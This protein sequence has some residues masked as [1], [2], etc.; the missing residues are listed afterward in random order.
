[1]ERSGKSR[2]IQGTFEDHKTSLEILS[3]E[4]STICSYQTPKVLP[5][6]LTGKLLQ[7]APVPGVPNFGIG[8]CSHLCHQEAVT[9]QFSNHCHSLEGEQN[10]SSQGHLCTSHI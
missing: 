3:G 10:C 5:S 6:P 2:G 4:P 9:L 8:V 7:S 1:M